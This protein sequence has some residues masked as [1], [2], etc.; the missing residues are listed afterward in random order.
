M[1]EFKTKKYK[2]LLQLLN[3]HVS[4]TD[5]LGDAHKVVVLQVEKGI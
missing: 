1:S 4:L 5:E 2:P 3:L